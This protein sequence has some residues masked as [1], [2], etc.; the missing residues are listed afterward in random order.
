MRPWLDRVRR[1]APVIVALTAVAAGAAAVYSFAAAKRYEARAELLVSPLPAH[2]TTFEGFTLPRQ[3]SA[4][5]ETAARLVR[6]DEIADVVRAQLGL[7]ES[8]SGVLSSVSSHR[9]DGSDL[10]AVVGKAS[11]PADAA[12]LANAFA[13]ALVAAQTGRFQAT[14]ATV[15]RRLRARLRAGASSPAERLALGR[16][17]GVLTGL[18]ATRDPTLEV[19]STA[20]APSDPVWPRPWL[21]IP[22]AAAAALAIA[23]LAAALVPHPA[24]PPAPPPRSEPAPEPEPEPEPEPSPPPPATGAW[25][26]GELR[27]LVE[28]RGA[29][30]PD[31]V[32]LWRS[33]L[34]VLEEH[35]GADGTLP[36]SFDALVEDEF[37][38]LLP[39]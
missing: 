37:R 29:S 38:E 19:A 34:S 4:A 6:T 23:T 32:E 30:Y 9:V 15:I 1:R 25:N 10:V 39:P 22:L 33:Y 5:A 20:V 7:R 35:A 16:R 31:R 27:R 28:E 17:L 21:I 12:Q 14:L 36:S 18:V 24:P 13:D 2:D 26:L 11:T 3:G 8:R